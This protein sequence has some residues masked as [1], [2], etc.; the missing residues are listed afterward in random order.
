MGPKRKATEA[1]AAASAKKPKVNG[2]ITNFFTKPAASAKKTTTASTTA[3]DISSDGAPNSITDVHQTS[4]ST[5]TWNKD[6]WVKTLTPQNRALLELEIKTMD[7]TWLRELKDELVSTHFINLK[8]FLQSE[9]DT[10]QKV[11][12]AEEDIYSW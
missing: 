2:T 8:K 6:A 12:P 10:G 9:K 11:Y 1:A 5:S 7:V 3:G 4:T